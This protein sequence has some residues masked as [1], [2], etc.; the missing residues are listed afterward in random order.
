MKKQLLYLFCGL[1]FAIQV[2]A[3]SLTTLSLDDLH[4]NTA[5]Q[6]D[7]YL[8]RCTNIKFRK[9]GSSAFSGDYYSYTVKCS[10]GRKASI[11]AWDNRSKWCVGK[12][13]KKKDC[14]DS[15]LK[16]ANMACNR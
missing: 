1:I 6:Y 9:R 10:N 2:N 16:A 4:Y 14:I 5:T 13:T 8:V 11:T 7:H 3:Q 15:Q 12:S